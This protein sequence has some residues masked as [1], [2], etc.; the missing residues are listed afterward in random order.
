MAPGDICPLSPPR[1][2]TESAAIR[3]ME[4]QVRDGGSRIF[5]EHSTVRMATLYAGSVDVETSGK[6]SF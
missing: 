2:A 6:L 5:Q 4:L 1:A 3:V